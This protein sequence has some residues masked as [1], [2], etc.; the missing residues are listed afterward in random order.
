MEF[1]E[2]KPANEKI[3]KISIIWLI[4]NW[5]SGNWKK[6]YL[7][8]LEIKKNSRGARM[9]VGNQEKNI[10]VGAK[11]KEEYEELL[12]ESSRKKRLHEI[13]EEKMESEL[14]H[15]KMWLI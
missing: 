14:R 8:D 7:L 9:W 11:N 1:K 13:G 5:I 4:K 15:F 6:I 12:R 3:Y 2:R 10:E